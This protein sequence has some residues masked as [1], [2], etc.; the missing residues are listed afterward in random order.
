MP[1]ITLNKLSDVKCRK[2][3][4]GRHSDGGGLYL[5]VKPTDAKNWLFVYRWGDKRPS[6]GF[7]GY[8]AVTLAEARKHASQCRDWLNE[9]PKKDPKKAW[10][11]L[12]SPE[13]RQETFGPFAFE[14]H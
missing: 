12:S 9:V 14:A 11:A 3:P 6:I 13:V 4:P 10:K 8:P 7:G 1:D 2:A 5:N